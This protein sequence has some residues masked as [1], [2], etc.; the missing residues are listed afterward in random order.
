VLH[1]A[2][3]TLE[4]ELLVPLI[5]EAKVEI[6]FATWLLAQNGQATSSTVFA[7]R[8]SS[9]K[10]DPQSWQT[11]SKIGINYSLDIKSGGHFLR[12][13]DDFNAVQQI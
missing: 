7:L 12:G 5:F 4:N 10:G 11:N 13:F 3:E 2:V 1:E 6:C 8:T 9:S